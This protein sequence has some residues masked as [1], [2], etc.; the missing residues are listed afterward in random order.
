MRLRGLR[1]GIRVVE[2][3]KLKL[4]LG[5]WVD[6]VDRWKEG[7]MCAGDAPVVIGN[8]SDCGWGWWPCITGGKRRVISLLFLLLKGVMLL[9]STGGQ[10][11]LEADPVR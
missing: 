5:H 2:L 6:V 8:Y 4:K 3:L 9:T 11:Y 10:V 1:D 7:E